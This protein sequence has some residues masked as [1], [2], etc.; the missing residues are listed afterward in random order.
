MGFNIKYE[1]KEY[2]DFFDHYTPLTEKCL[3]EIL[4]II[5]FKIEKIIPRFLAYTVKSNIRKNTCLIKLYLR[6]LF[7]WKIMEKQMLIFARKP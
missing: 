4:K 6:M 2:W 5:G 3:A 7:I 1:Y